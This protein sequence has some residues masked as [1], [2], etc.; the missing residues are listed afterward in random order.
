MTALTLFIAEAGSAAS[1]VSFH[2]VG[3]EFILT[4]V[5]PGNRARARIRIR[6]G[7]VFLLAHLGASLAQDGCRDY[8]PKTY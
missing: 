3:V 4:A 6:W 2:Q 1:F 5:W 7:R 8:A